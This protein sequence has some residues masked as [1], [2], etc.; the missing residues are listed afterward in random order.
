MPE[1]AKRC[2]EMWRELS[3]EEKKPYHVRFEGTLLHL[4]T[5]IMRLKATM[6]VL[7]AQCAP[8]F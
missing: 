6:R 7:P 1:V 4:H 3:D 5:L 2:G 8:C